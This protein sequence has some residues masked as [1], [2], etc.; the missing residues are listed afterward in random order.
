[1]LNQLIRKAKKEGHR[2]YL[3]TGSRY[4]TAYYEKVFERYDLTYD[5]ECLPDVFESVS[6]DVTLFMGAFD[7]NFRWVNEER[8]LVRFT[9]GLTNML[10]AHDMSCTVRFIFLS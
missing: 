2:V 8:E 3:L 7:T 6:P 1:M 10:T 9:S 5:S 4:T